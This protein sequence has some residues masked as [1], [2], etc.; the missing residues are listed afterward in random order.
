MRQRREADFIMNFEE[1]EQAEKKYDELIVIG[2]NI[3]KRN[4]IYHIAG[5][6]RC[7][8][9]A[10]LYVLEQEDSWR[11][12]DEIQKKSEIPKASE[13]QTEYTNRMSM[14]SHL[15]NNYFFDIEELKIGNSIYSAKTASS[16]CLGMN[17]HEMLLLFS[18]ML[19]AG[20]KA[21]DSPFWSVDW[22]RLILTETTF[23]MIEKKLPVWQGEISVKLHRRHK[24][25]FVEQP[26]CLTVGEESKIEFILEDRRKYICYINKVSPIDVWKEQEEQF[27]NPKYL[28]QMTEEE[29]EKMKQRFYSCLE[30]NCPKGMCYLGIEYECN[31][32]GNI[33]FYDSAFLDT[34]QRV[35]SGS[36]ASLMM[37]LKPDEP[38][39][40]HGYKNHGCIIQTP[41]PPDVQ[42][43][44]AELFQFVELLPE[45]EELLIDEI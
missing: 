23:E 44:S 25:Y 10:V 30:Q 8:T 6:T 13:T 41:V 36:A 16:G 2:K 4:R 3:E 1:L 35:Y 45:K 14:K 29:F 15:Q 40:K 26:V 33:V 38:I 42:K 5:M 22:D 34:E 18:D 20:W 9:Q 19:R 39:G 7:G 27:Q 31:I 11:E 37:L 43:L 24:T 21:Q 17:N 12:T 28:E 32:E